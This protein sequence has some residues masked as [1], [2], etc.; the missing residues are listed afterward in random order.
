MP[1]TRAHTTLVVDRSGSMIDMKVEAE[2]GVAAYLKTL[3]EVKDAKVTVSLY[4]FDTAFEPVYVGVK[5]KDAPAYVLEPR[6]ATALY[7]AVGLG[8]EKTKD[9]I[10]SLAGNQRPEKVAIVIVT[11]GHE[12]SSREHTFES[13]KKL[14]ETAQADGWE[15][16]FLAGTPDA[17]RFGQASGLRTTSYNSRLRGQTVSVYAAA[18]TA[19]ADF[20][21]GET[22]TMATPET[23]EDAEQDE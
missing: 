3:A 14:I 19:N 5:P 7:D 2:G 8:L 22:A 6:A 15:V 21:V 13:Q 18:A 9:Y 1:K 4:Q 23:V 12:N 10:E 20:F 16:V 17:V 11:D